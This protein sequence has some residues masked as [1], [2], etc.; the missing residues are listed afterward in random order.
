MLIA[1]VEE[2]RSLCFTFCFH[3]PINVFLLFHSLFTFTIGKDD[4]GAVNIGELFCQVWL[5]K[6]TQRRDEFNYH[7]YNFLTLFMD[8]V[9]DVL[10]TSATQSSLRGFMWRHLFYLIFNPLNIRQCWNARWIIGPI[11]KYLF[12]PNQKKV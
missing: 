10:N 3:F 2:A 5:A 4:S 9:F 7:F 11:K 1:D 6:L 12:N 8:M